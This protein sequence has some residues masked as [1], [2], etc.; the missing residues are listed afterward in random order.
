M[1]QHGLCDR[2][3]KSA[4]CMFHEDSRNSFSAY[5]RKDGTWAWKCHAGC[6]G[7]DEA[8]WLA[9]HLNLSNAEACREYIRLAGVTLPPAA[10]QSCKP[11]RSV[12]SPFDWSKCVDSFTSQHLEKIAKWRGYSSKSVE[13]LHAQGL[14]GLFDGDH[15]AFPVHD[16]QGSAIGCHY[17]RNED[18]S[19]R[20]HPIGTRTAP[21]VIGKLSTAKSIFVFE[22]QWDMLALLNCLDWSIAPLPDTAAVCTRG[23]GNARLLAGLCA[24]DAVVRAFGQ[25]DAAGQKW[26]AAV[27]THCGCKCVQVV[28]PPPHKDLNDWTRAGATRP[29][30]EAAIA[31]AQLVTVSTAPDLHAAPPKNVSNPAITL[32][33]EADE[34]ETA[35]FPVDA[36]PSAMANIIE[37][38]SRCERVPLALPAVCAL[39][40]ASAAI[41]AGL[42]VASGPNRVTRGNLYL[43][44][45]AE[46][47]SGK[48]ETFRIIAAPLVSHQAR[49][50]ETWKLETAPQAQSEIRVLEREMDILEKQAAKATEPMERDRA[51][52]QMKFKQ[53]SKDELK[54]RAEMPCII[55]Q[56][57]TTERL[58]GLLRDNR[59]VLL[60][61]SADARKLVDNLLGRYNPGKT[62]DESLYLSAYSGDY[63]RVDRQGR[64]SV[65]LN[66][67]CLALCW[68]VQ[69]DLLI[70]LFDEE[71]LSA[72]GFLPRLLLCQTNAAPRRIESEP[73][74]LS[75]SVCG[76]WA[77][78]IG[79][80]HA[81]FHAADKPHTVTPSPEALA[82]LNVYHNRI[83]D[84]RADDLADV[85]AF[86]ARYAENAW[87]VA[88]LLH[89][90]QWGSEAS[91]AQLSEETGSNAVRIVEWFASSQ[92]AILA[93][94]RHAAAAKVADEVLELLEHNRERKGLDSITA[95]DVHRARITATPDAA[96]ALLA[97][98]EA[99]G[100]LC[101]EEIT[102]TRGGK[103]MRIYRAVTNPIPG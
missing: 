30:I 34:A 61:A 29:E 66:S 48:S 96:K 14:I 46:S 69:P 15:V 55:G 76:Q 50:L 62:T 31:A 57:V 44:A 95:R 17:R 8:D 24:P 32:P 87:R 45:S 80:L 82:V 37:A 102:P 101:G 2:A 12:Q 75:D 5:R 13:W 16:A 20:Y 54:R 22:S 53:A 83:V 41:G 10:P 19:W 103:T 64:D 72:S 52:A 43:L 89:A 73:Q 78:L 35:P 99:D 86:A 94:G 98:M 74:I 59:E 3:K 79:D 21:F 71:S 85:G 81:N 63:V 56:D 18:S 25:N 38:V 60:S 1:A 27:A 11:S 28:T 47:G 58:A 91:Q 93:K 65:I 36:L 6:G 26:L 67:P 51:I 49:L 40:I 100:L 88:V 9:K 92:L 39:G 77:Q 90:V 97:R 70:K 33:Q 84:R 7:G 4:R 42:Q 23:A 68:F